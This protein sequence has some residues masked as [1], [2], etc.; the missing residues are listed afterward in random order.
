MAD[1]RKRVLF[2]TATSLGD[3]VLTSGL[4]RDAVEN[5]PDAWFTVAAG[6]TAAPLFRDTPRLEALI[7]V[8]KR[9]R[10]RHWFDLWRKVAGGKW[11]VVIDMRGS[12]VPYLVRARRRFVYRPMPASAPPLHKALQAARTIGRLADP[13]S[14]FL[15]ASAATEGLAEALVPPGAAVLAIAP[16]AGRPHKIWPTERFAETALALLGPGGP[17]AGARVFVTGADSERSMCADLASALG[18]SRT[19]DAVGLDPL[20]TYA[21]LK[22]VRLFLGNDSGMMHLA[23]AAGAPT[24]GL[25]GPTD[26]RLYHPWGARTAIVRSGRALRESA[27]PA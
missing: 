13:P 1:G 6:P 19:I 8:I 3:A 17:L 7:P 25:F 10:G 21:C 20:T 14:P 15:Y 22:R 27:I 11:D 16:G 5:D 9:P 2:I 23:A 24:L 4:L 18:V 12:L 26:D